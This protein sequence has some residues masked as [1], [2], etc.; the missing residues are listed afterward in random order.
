MQSTNNI[1]QR[2]PAVNTPKQTIHRFVVPDGAHYNE[3]IG[4]Y[5]IWIAGECIGYDSLSYESAHRHYIEALRTRREHTQRPPKNQTTIFNTLEKLIEA[6]QLPLPN[7]PETVW[8]NGTVQINIWR[9][10]DDRICLIFKAGK[11]SQVISD[12][13][14]YLGR[15]DSHISAPKAQWR[16]YDDARCKYERWVELA[17]EARG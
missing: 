12:P 16:L 1:P 8:K 14:G 2:T 9:R 5:E 3:T 17:R 11:Y 10:N 15:D 4:E 7:K 6:N 13:L